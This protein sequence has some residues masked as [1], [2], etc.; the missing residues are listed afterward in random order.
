[1]VLTVPTI[2]RRIGSG[3]QRRARQ[4]VGECRIPTQRCA[5]GL[6][7]GFEQSHVRRVTGP[8][9]VDGVDQ[10]D[11]LGFAVVGVDPNPGRAGTGPG[12]PREDSVD[13]RV[14]VGDPAAGTAAAVDVDDDDRG[15]LGVGQGNVLHP[16][17]GGVADPV[18]LRHALALSVLAPR[19]LELT[20]GTALERCPAQVGDE[21]VALGIG[22]PTRLQGGGYRPEVLDEQ[23][24]GVCQG[25][26]LLRRPGPTRRKGGQPTG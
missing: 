3:V 4:V 10:P 7:G 20:G 2:S 6:A 24:G 11:Q 26:A 21:P 15:V 12:E 8:V 25:T 14:D 5:Q 18:H 16:V 23:A 9:G 17:Q 22:G 1:M 13:I 19:G